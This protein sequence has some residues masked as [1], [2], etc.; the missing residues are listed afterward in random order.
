MAD[1][2][3]LVFVICQLIQSSTTPIPISLM[4]HG[5]EE[6]AAIIGAVVER[7][8]KEGIA[9]AQ[10]CMDPE[11]GLEL[12]LADGMA[13]PHGERPTVHIEEGL[14]RQVLFKGS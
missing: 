7:C 2:A 8:S 11:L 13:L 9:L 14:G 6:A 3:E 5:V 1:E 12:G 4:N 10:V